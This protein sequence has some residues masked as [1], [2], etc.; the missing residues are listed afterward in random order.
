M[1]G[2]S[3]APDG[4][5]NQQ[6]KQMTQTAVRDSEI[7]RAAIVMLHEVCLGLNSMTMKS[8]EYCLP[9]ATLSEKGS[10]KILKSTIVLPSKGK[11]K[12][13]Y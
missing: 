3:I 11:N 13:E 9:I 6:V 2:I 10:K 5:S 12:Q 4:N 7:I 8:L 1:L